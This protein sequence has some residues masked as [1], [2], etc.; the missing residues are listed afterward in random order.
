MKK[1]ILYTLSGLLLFAGCTTTT[2]GF[3]QA[4]ALIV[5]HDTIEAEREASMVTIKVRSL[6]PYEIRNTGTWITPSVKRGDPG[7]SEFTLKIAK[8]ETVDKR[9]VTITVQNQLYG[10]SHY[11][12]VTQKAG[13]PNISISKSSMETSVEG[14]NEAITITSNISWTASCSA[15]WVTLS[16][17]EGKKGETT[18]NI[19]TKE[20]VATVDRFATVKITN[21]EYNITKKIQ[22]SQ[23]KLVPE[24]EVD[25]AEILTSA[26]SETKSVYITSNIPWTASCDADWVT[27]SHTT[28]KKGETA[29]NI[30]TKANAATVN[31]SATVK[32]ANNEYDKTATIN[33]KQY[34][35]HVILYTSSNGKVTPYKSD[36]FGANI[37]FNTYA[38][39]QGELLFDA[40]ITSIGKSAFY[41]CRNLTSVTIPDSVTSIGYGAFN[42]CIGLTSVTIPDSVTTIGNSAFYNCTSLTSV[43]IP[44]SVTTIGNSA[45]DDCSSLTSITIP[46]SVTTI[47]NYAFFGCTSLTSI[48][49]PNSVTSIGDDAFCSCGLTSV[50]IPDSVTSIGN[51]AFA[52]CHSLTSITIPN[53]VTSIGH[54]AFWGCTSLTS[55][56]IPNSVTKIG[57][58]VFYKCTSLTSVYCKPTTPPTG[59]D[60]SMFSY[61]ASGRKIYVPSDSVDAY[62]AASYW[63]DYASDIEG[64]NF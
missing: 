64:Y 6:V 24:L 16:H 12:T 51:G 30:T 18:L 15:D 57:G 13:E 40:P 33:I 32:I 47:G 59:D 41:D 2:E 62:K 60:Y 63:S 36:G 29:L 19:T 34:G 44:N 9:S 27:L 4:E 21:S 54:S 53:S 43:T 37:V 28:G 42:S 52:Y 49:I 50:T 45:F 1:L 14:G 7:N 58:Y 25:V 38:N 3:E 22:I 17:K 11:I 20:N 55:V 26:A 56:T 31:R 10:L 35:Y 46:N 23:A 39:G 61:N 48:T 8:N 5:S